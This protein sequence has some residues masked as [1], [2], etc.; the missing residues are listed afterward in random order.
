MIAKHCKYVP[1]IIAHH[2]NQILKLNIGN[3][4]K[5]CLRPPLLSTKLHTK[6][7]ANRGAKKPILRFLSV[8]V[9]FHV[10]SP[11]LS[12][13]NLHLAFEQQ[14]KEKMEWPSQAFRRISMVVF[15]ACYITLGKCAMDI[16]TLGLTLIHHSY[17]RPN[18]SYHFW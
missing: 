18:K 15:V 3:S 10:T 13:W 9:G 7:E 17:T 5:V 1:I 16:Q 4:R 11:S 12:K 8:V 6:K 14:K 2:Q